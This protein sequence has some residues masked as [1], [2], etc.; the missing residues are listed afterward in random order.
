MRSMVLVRY[1]VAA[2]GL[3]ALGV[4]TFQALH[5]SL[6][7]PVQHMRIAWSLTRVL[8]QL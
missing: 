6:A 5:L 8:L 2:F 4:A 3:A 7:I 1:S